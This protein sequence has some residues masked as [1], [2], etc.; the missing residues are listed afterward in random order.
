MLEPTAAIREAAMPGLGW[1]ALIV[2]FGIVSLLLEWWL[3]TRGEH[4]V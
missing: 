4:D 3:R 1:L 2:A